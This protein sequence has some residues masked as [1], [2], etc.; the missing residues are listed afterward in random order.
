M[1]EIV[2]TI[3]VVPATAEMTATVGMSERTG[4]LAK[5]KQQH[6]F[7]KQVGALA[8]VPATAE[9]TTTVGMQERAGTPAT[10][11]TVAKHQQ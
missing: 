6:W 2:V 9:M 11:G 8:E 3:A 10:A 7:L 5:H 4:T 1:P